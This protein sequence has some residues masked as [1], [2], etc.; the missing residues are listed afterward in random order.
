MLSQ[1]QVLSTWFLAN[2]T[3]QGAC[4][5]LRRCGLVEK[6]QALKMVAPGSNPAVSASRFRAM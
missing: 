1:T 4:G 5:V 2:G 6:E 3:V